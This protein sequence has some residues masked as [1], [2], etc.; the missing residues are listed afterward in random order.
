MTLKLKEIEESCDV[1][2]RQTSCETATCSFVLAV[3]LGF[4]E[5]PIFG[6]SPEKEAVEAIQVSRACNKHVTASCT[7]WIPGRRFV[8]SPFQKIRF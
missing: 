2:V 4:S 1:S 3:I 5:L 8:F 7:S 6:E